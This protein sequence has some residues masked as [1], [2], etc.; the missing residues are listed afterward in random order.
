M[1]IVIPRN[2]NL[3][4][5]YLWGVKYKIDV[6]FEVKGNEVRVIME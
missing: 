5:V 2:R 4:E 3:Q 1:K 6:T